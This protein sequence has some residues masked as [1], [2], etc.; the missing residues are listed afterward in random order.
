MRSEIITLTSSPTFCAST[1]RTV[2][3]STPCASIALIRRQH[4]AVE[5]PT[6]SARSA[7]LMSP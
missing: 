2:P 4:D 6:A 3:V 1:S 7:W 5:A